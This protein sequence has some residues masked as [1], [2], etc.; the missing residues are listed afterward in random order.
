[1][2]ATIGRLEV[3]STGLVFLIT[4]ISD[5]M[6]SVLLISLNWVGCSRATGIR[7]TGHQRG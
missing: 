3:T 6:E 4:S 7:T 1:M 2:P 5:W